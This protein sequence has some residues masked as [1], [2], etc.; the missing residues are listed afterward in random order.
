VH[1]AK[2]WKVVLEPIV[3]RYRD[4]ELRRYFR[5]D[6]AFANPASTSIWSRRDSD[7]LSGCLPMRIW[8]MKS[9]TL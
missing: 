3:T 6:A 8:H 9:L 2:D 7:T 1:S 4:R 5:G